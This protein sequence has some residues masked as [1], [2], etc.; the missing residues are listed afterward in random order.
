VLLLYLLE[1]MRVSILDEYLDQKF[2][3]LDQQRIDMEQQINVRQR[4]INMHVKI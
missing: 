2:A 1:R 4:R 3:E